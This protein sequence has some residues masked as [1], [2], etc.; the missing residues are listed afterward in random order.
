MYNTCSWLEGE[1]AAHGQQLLSI[2]WGQFAGI[3]GPSMQCLLIRH[4][5]IPFPPPLWLERYLKVGKE[6]NRKK[7]RSLI[8]DLQEITEPVPST[9]F[10]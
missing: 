8:N 5:M 6:K 3:T 9:D 4:L 2:Q 1:S 7:N 10:G